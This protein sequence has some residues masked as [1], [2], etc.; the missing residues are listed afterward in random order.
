MKEPP[1]PPPAKEQKEKRIQSTTSIEV[2]NN[3]IP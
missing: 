3:D 1:R 2:P